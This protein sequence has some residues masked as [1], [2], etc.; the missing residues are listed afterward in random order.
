MLWDCIPN[1]LP[2]L[3]LLLLAVFSNCC[4]CCCCSQIIYPLKTFETGV[5]C[6]VVVWHW[7]P[8]NTM[9]KYYPLS[10]WTHGHIIW[11]I[12][13][14]CKSSFF[15][16]LLY[17]IAMLSVYSM[18]EGVIVTQDSTSFQEDFLVTSVKWWLSVV[19]LLTEPR[20]TH[21]INLHR[22]KLPGAGRSL[23][24]PGDQRF[25]ISRLSWSR[26][27]MSTQ[28]WGW[29]FVDLE[30]EEEELSHCFWTLCT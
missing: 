5:V 20:E 13:R 14:H 17:V 11:C 1:T 10:H 29:S 9:C 22:K 18:R 2:T 27:L 15:F 19:S 28:S 8:S 25:I 16:C 24:R 26:V 6:R 23:L 30:L 3:S 12:L 7:V 4:C 21:K